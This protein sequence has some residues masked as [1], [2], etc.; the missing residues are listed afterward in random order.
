MFLSAVVDAVR[1][2]LLAD[3]GTGGIGGSGTPL[4]GG[5]FSVARLAGATSTPFAVIGVR[6]TQDATFGRGRWN[7][8]FTITIHTDH[9]NGI[10]TALTA[11]DRI[12][13]NFFASAPVSSSF[14]LHGWAPTSDLSVSGYTVNLGEFRHVETDTPLLDDNK[15]AVVLTFESA[16]NVSPGA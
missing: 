8:A 1:D 11:H 15:A 4:P 10:D 16:V 9:Q 7:L 14:G 3:N 6:S 12:I 2:R 13:G 5:V